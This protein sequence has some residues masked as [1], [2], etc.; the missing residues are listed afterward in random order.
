MLYGRYKRKRYPTRRLTR[1][2]R[3]RKA[4]PRRKKF[5]ASK[6]TK[7]IIRQPSSL[8]DRL[9]VKLNYFD[10]LT[11]SSNTGFNSTQVYRGNSLFDPDLTNTGHQP[12]GFDQWA[13]FYGS[14]VVHG[15]KISLEGQT[16][17]GN[18]SNSSSMTW[19][20]LP[21][22]SSSSFASGS[23]Q[24]AEEPY[25][26]SRSIGAN[27]LTYNKLKRYMTTRKMF[28]VPKVNSEGSDN[29]RA[30]VSANPTNV[31]Y[32]IIVAHS[33]DLAASVSQIA[34]IKLTFYCEFFNR[35]RLAQS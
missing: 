11:F 5:L 4:L 12:L 29:Y 19:T 9:F 2:A 24:P 1:F 28:G 22:L 13:N 27:N 20:I 34:R 21:N 10:I 23:E 15:S 17:E 26:T 3:R 6:A 30:L 35:N 32:W 8:P 16:T 18:A 14:Y 25:A 33:T 7:V 31:W